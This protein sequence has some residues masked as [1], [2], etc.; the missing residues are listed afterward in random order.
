MATFL[1]LAQKLARESGTVQGDAT[2]SSVVN[3]T[4][5]LLK[6]VNWVIDAWKEIQNLHPS[7]RFRLKEFD[8]QTLT[9]N[10]MEYTAAT[11]NI[12]DHHDWIQGAKADEPYWIYDPDIG[13]SDQSALTWLDWG[14]FRRQYRKGTHTAA[15]PVHF[16]VSPTGNLYIGPKPDKAYPIEGQYIRTPQALAANDEVPICKEAFHE[17]IV[18]YALVYLAEHDEAA[19]SVATAQRKY[20]NYLADLEG[21]ELPRPTTAG[22]ALA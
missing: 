11:L 1:Q 10:T 4:G 8:G 2:P 17:I 12:T 3:Q 6:V 22:T 16:S 21:S 9:L 18:W 13:E 5:R 14:D 20:D 15:R 7:W 19:F